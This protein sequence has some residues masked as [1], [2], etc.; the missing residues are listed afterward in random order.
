MKQNEYLT[1]IELFD[2]AKEEIQAERMKK[3]LSSFED[4]SLL[5]KQSGII[6]AQIILSNFYKD[7]KE[8]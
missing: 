3:G 6:H 7:N 2:K 5:G 4:L 1:L 8:V